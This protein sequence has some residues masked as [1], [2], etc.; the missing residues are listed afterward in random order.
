MDIEIIILNEEVKDK[1]SCDSTYMWNLKNYSN[2]LIYKT[3]RDSQ[4]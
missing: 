1:I 2:E 3:E 4:T